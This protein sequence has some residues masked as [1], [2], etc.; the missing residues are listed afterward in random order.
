MNRRAYTEILTGSDNLVPSHFESLASQLQLSDK[1]Y[2]ESISRAVRGSTFA[3]EALIQRFSS[4]SGLF[5]ALK[6]LELRRAPFSALLDEPAK[7]SASG[8][9]KK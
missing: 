8:S 5:R 3:H 6:K 7:S 4:D 9:I 1:D 2:A